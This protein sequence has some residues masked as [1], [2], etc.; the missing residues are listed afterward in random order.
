MEDNFCEKNWKL[1]KT[2][3]TQGILEEKENQ[4]IHKKLK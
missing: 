4:G 2:H 3:K 1:G